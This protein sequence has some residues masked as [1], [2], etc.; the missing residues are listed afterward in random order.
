MSSVAVLVQYLKGKHL[1]ISGSIPPPLPSSSPHFLSSFGP[2]SAVDASLRF[3][4]EVLW[5]SPSLPSS[6]VFPSTRCPAPLPPSL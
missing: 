3:T 6:S 2:H 5:T 1:I 4:S